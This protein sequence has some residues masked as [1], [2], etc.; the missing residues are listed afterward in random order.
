M[1]ADR[2]FAKRFGKRI[3]ARMVNEILY[4]MYMPPFTCSVVPVM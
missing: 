4:D 1:V 2:L 3:K